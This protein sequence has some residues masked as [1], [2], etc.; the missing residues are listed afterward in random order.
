MYQFLLNISKKTKNSC[1]ELN[2]NLPKNNLKIIFVHPLTELEQHATYHLRKTKE[3]CAGNYYMYHKNLPKNNSK[4]VQALPTQW[5]WASCHLGRPNK[6]VLEPGVSPTFAITYF[7]NHCNI[8]PTP[9]V[10]HER[11]WKQWLFFKT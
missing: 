2:K 3:I 10:I 7:Y 4:K 8:S 11:M 1:R 9:M 5:V 6:A